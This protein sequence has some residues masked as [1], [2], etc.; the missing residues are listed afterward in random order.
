MLGDR[1]ASVQL[2][3]RVAPLF[4]WFAERV[5]I[6]V[7][8]YSHSEMHGTK[9]MTPTHNALW[10]TPSGRYAVGSLTTP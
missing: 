6:A 9:I 2:L 10:M 7:M 3:D 5:I 8:S 4:G 1:S